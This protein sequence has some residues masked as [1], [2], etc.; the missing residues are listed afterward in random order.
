MNRQMCPKLFNLTEGTV[1]HQNNYEMSKSL[2]V[3]ISSYYA[4]LNLNI[5]IMN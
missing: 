2:K 4:L 5:C 1:S 3:V